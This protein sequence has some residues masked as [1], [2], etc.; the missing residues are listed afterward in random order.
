MILYSC[1]GGDIHYDQDV[2]V[3]EGVRARFLQI[4]AKRR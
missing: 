2:P 1:H 4:S 3:V